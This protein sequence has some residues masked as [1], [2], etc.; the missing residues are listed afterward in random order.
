MKDLQNDTADRAQAYQAARMRRAVIEMCRGPGQGYAGQ[1][2]ELADVMAVLFHGHLREQDRFVLS[3]GHAAIALYAALWSIGR[4]TDEQIRTYGYDGTHVEE[5]PLDDLDGFEVTGGSLGQGPSQAAGMA[6]GERMRGSDAHVVCEVSDGE[7]QEGSVW[8]A[9]MF[10]AARD[11]SNLTLLVNDNGEQADGA[12]AEVLGIGPLAP[13]FEAFGLH[14]ISVDGHD[15]P[16]LRDALDA[17]RAHD[18]PAAV[19]ARTVPGK[20]VTTFDRFARVH[21]VRTD[22]DTWQNAADELDA[23]LAALG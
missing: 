7:L 1:G 3:T 17:A 8:E 18:G 14:A 16:A 6:L 21:Y 22:A 9:V 15:I 5:S 2:L 4:M 19:I 13:K 20:G 12:T 11:L 10:A 23:A